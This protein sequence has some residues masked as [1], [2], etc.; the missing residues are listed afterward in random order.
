M[1]SSPAGHGSG[2][3]PGVSGEGADA[4]AHPAS[5]MM[6]CCPRR[7]APPPDGFRPIR[8]VWSALSVYGNTDQTRRSVEHPQVD[9]AGHSSKNEAI[10]T[11]APRIA[12][13]YRR[14][15]TPS[16]ELILHSR[17]CLPAVGPVPARRSGCRKGRPDGPD[18]CGSQSAARGVRAAKGAPLGGVLG[19]VVPD[20]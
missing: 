19:I 5:V 2:R 17:S 4:G 7:V 3:A 18:L 10:S 20:P 6:W 13:A 1:P 8:R 16:P 15:L 9:P 11:S 12:F 14:N